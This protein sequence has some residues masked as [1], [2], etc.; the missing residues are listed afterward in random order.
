MRV[1]FYT[2]EYQSNDARFAAATFGFVGHED[3]NDSACIVFP[4]EINGIMIQGTYEEC[5]RQI[6]NGEWK[7][8]IV[9]L[10]NAGNEN[11]FVKALSKKVR[12]P[13]VGGGAAIHPKT[14]EKGL[15]TGKGQAAVF[16]ID[17]T[18]YQFEV[19]CENIH[20]DILSEHEI[21]FRDARVIEAI[22]GQEPKEW[23]KNQKEKLG[24]AE[25]DFE[26]L[27]LADSSGINA[28][29]SECD[30]KI[31]SG[32]DLT[33]R[34]QL[35]YVSED[36]VWERMQAFYND[37]DAI[38]FGCAGL[39]GIL[40]AKLK[41]EGVGLFLFGEVCT[42]DNKSEFGNLMLSKIKVCER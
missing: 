9:L 22:D 40:P 13:L 28:H 30:G 12:A 29:L 8:G 16:L 11:A 24:L 38:V 26:H 36:K 5:L 14:G 31:C 18:R 1:E 7:A 6:P 32:R 25:D 27:T 35:R 2:P 33:S 3:E 21:T 42:K 20:H 4:K 10:G 34:M 15:I 41:T 39:K 19:S 37:K 17:D 23:L